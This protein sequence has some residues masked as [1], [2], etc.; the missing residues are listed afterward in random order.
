MK[1]INKKALSGEAIKDILLW[2]VFII[3]GITVV[4]LI[5]KSIA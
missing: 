4:T 5:V 1:S 2:I 3:I